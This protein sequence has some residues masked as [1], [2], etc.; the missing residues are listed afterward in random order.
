MYIDAEAVITVGK[1]IGALAVIGGVLI[2]AYKFCQHPKEQD[3]ALAE[4]RKE[5]RE[6]IKA[7]S[8]EQCLII[9]GVLACL[10]GLKEQGCNGT[11]TETILKIEK[12]LNE[13]AH[14]HE[15]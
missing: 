13:Q 3:K 6:D 7:I 8:E 14:H 10:R 1:V 5:H 4:L 2:T 11:V 9:Y 15:D 12:H